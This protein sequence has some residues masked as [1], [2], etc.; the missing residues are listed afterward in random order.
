VLPT[1]HVLRGV[2]LP[3]G[4]HTVAL[5]YDPL[6]LR[7]GLWISGFAAVAMLTGFV[8]AVWARVARR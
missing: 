4:Q 3:A 1:H 2:P 8:V 7:V 5:R 6:S